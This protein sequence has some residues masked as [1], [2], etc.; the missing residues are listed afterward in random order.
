MTILITLTTPTTDAGPFNIYS[1][2]DGFLSAFAIN[3][4]KA[5]LLSGYIANNVPDGTT[6]VKLVSV[7]EECNNYIDFEI[8]ETTTTTTTTTEN[9]LDYGN[10]FNNIARELNIQTDNKYL[11]IGDFTTYNDVISNRIVKINNDGSIDSTFV[12]GTGFGSSVRDAEIQADGKIVIG[13]VFTTYN[14]TTANR[15]LRLNTDG[16][17]DNTFNTGSGLNG[18]VIDIEIQTDGKILLGGAFTTYN[19]E[20][21]V[22]LIRLNSDGTRDSSFLRSTN[23]NNGV[24]NIKVL[25]DGKIIVVG[26]FTLY[27]GV[28]LSR[29]V[30]LNSDGTIDGTFSIGTGFQTSE[31]NYIRLQPD[32]KIII[33]GQFTGY[34]DSP[35]NRIIR[36]NSDGT[37]DTSFAVATGF[38]SFVRYIALQ[39]DGKI[40]VGGD[41]TTYNGFSRSR[42]IRLNDDSSIDSTFNIGSGFNNNVHD[43][44]VE[45]SGKILVTGDFTLYNGISTNRI[46]RLNNDGSVDTCSELL[47]API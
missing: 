8:Q 1:D 23:T 7:G 42:I 37:R 47:T 5:T 18:A 4:D 15:I 29:I 3:I 9:C 6:V 21:N 41:F 46:I 13:G 34:N 28:S 44:K 24:Q 22:S 32:G 39:S 17:I 16:T 12:I 31:A 25:P 11:V 36:L 43:I 45:A 14:G 26:I 20:S 35:S 30:K 38:N 10:G 33:G 27:N 40:L 2:V 19:G